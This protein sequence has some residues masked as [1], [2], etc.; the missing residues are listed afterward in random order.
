MVSV[1]TCEVELLMQDRDISLVLHWNFFIIS[2]VEIN[3]GTGSR[4]YILII[5][6]SKLDSEYSNN[7]QD[8]GRCSQCKTFLS[9]L[10]V[11]ATEEKVEPLAPG[12]V[13]CGKFWGLTS[14][15]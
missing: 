5:I 15:I 6:N 14:R 11:L 9:S 3:C 1:I 13:L 7:M 2:A 4:T 10:R 12:F 8:K